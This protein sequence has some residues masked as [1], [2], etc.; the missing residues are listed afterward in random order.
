[1]HLCVSM[2][3]TPFIAH[4]HAGKWGVTVQ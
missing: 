3:L 4:Y 1:M 2:T